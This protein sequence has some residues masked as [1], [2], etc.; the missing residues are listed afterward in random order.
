[1]RSIVQ[2]LRT[3]F[4]EELNIFSAFCR[5]KRGGL[6]I[7]WNHDLK[8]SVFVAG[9][10]RA[11]TTWLAEIVNA[12]NSFRDIFEPFNPT[13]V[14]LV[15]HFHRRQYLRPTDDDP[16][17]LEP[18]RAVFSGMLR[19]DWTDQLNRRIFCSK[20]L[21]KEIRTNLMLK[22]IRDHFPEMPIVF[23]LRHPCAVAISR[24]AKGWNSFYGLKDLLSQDLLI[25]DH[26][27][28]F[29]PIITA[30]RS[31]FEQHVL[32]WC[33]ENYVPVRTLHKNDA[34]VV[35]YE[36]LCLQPETE[37]KRLADYL[38]VQCP[39]LMMRRVSVPS[40]QARKGESAIVLGEN[41]VSSWKN[42]VNQDMLDQAHSLLTLFGLERFYGRDP[43]PLLDSNDVLS[44]DFNPSLT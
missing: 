6:H 17:Y 12:D 14:P 20:R 11:G 36:N 41:L 29:M 5:R 10:G 37:V 18:A 33:I 1:M 35:F 22:W 4:V 2:R 34:L 24:L 31:D 44:G 19:S 39:E 32:V 30:D 43:L 9:S 23:L 13:K 3:L 16:R 38:K 27:K 26:L 25:W 7:D 42:A 15:K 21:I 40:S 28:P 8:N